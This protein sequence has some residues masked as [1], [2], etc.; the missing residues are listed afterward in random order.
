MTAKVGSDR[1]EDKIIP[2]EG[3]TA[4]QHL[5]DEDLTSMA[6]RDVSY[7]VG[8]FVSTVVLV[9]IVTC[10]SFLFIPSFPC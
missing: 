2:S 5:Q 7:D 9:R 10:Q 1:N 8:T 6:T 4:V 3:N